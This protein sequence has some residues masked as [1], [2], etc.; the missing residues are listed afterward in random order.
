ML[1]WYCYLV[2]N[3]VP[4]LFFRQHFGC[5]HPK[6]ADTLIDYGYYL[7]NVDAINL[8]VKVYRVSISRHLSCI[9]V[10]KTLVLPG[11]C[12]TPAQPFFLA[13]QCPRVLCDNMKERLHRRLTLSINF[14]ETGAEKKIKESRLQEVSVECSEHYGH[15]FYEQEE[16]NESKIVI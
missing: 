2:W 6:Y 12:K 4:S 7:L 8:S 15:H 3:I 16:C 14:K 11:F 9:L 5:N 10:V 1:P 13:K